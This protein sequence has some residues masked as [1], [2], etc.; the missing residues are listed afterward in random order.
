[1]TPGELITAI[2]IASIPG[3]AIAVVSALLGRKNANRKMIVEEGA[4]ETTKFDSITA[5]YEDLL[6]RSEAATADHKASAEEAK[7]AAVEASKAAASAQAAA[8]AALAEAAE[9][10]KERETLVNTVADQGEKLE[11]LRVLF[12]KVIARNNIVL[13][14]EELEEFEAT[15]PVARSRKR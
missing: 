1:M 8:D 9:Y 7:A 15:K 13:T 11:R 5:K 2:L 4:L 10:K 6:E 12:E 3:T 14:T